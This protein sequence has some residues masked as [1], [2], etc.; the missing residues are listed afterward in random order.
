MQ[1][2]SKANQAR[3]LSL[4]AFLL[5]FRVVSVSAETVSSNNSP[6]SFLPEQ[7]SITDSSGQTTQL[8][9]RM[10]RLSGQL[11][12]VRLEKGLLKKNA[13]LS[14]SC[15]ASYP[16]DLRVN[17]TL[18]PIDNKYRYSL[19]ITVQ[20]AG[21]KKYSP[22]PG[23][24]LLLQ[25]GPGLVRGKKYTPSLYNYLRPIV[26]YNDEVHSFQPEQ[27]KTTNTGWARHQVSW[28]GLHD[29]YFAVLIEPE[30]K[31]GHTFEEIKAVYP[32]VAPYAKTELQ[33][34]LPLQDI[35]AGRMTGYAFK[36][37][38][39]PKSLDTLKP[40]Y[41]DILF[42]KLWWWLRWLSLGLVKLLGWIHMLIPSWGLAIIGLALFVRLLL[43]PIAK[44]ANASQKRFIEIQ[45]VMQ[46]ELTEIK[47]N[48]KG[49]EQSERMMAL[50]KKYNISPFSGMKPIGV[51]LVQLPILVALFQVLGAAYELRGASFLWINSLADP[52]KLFAFGTTLP[53]FGE[54][55]NILPVLMTVI[56][57]VSMKLTPAH[58]ATKQEK[59]R[60]NIFLLLMSAVFFLLFYS[61]PAG[62]VLYWTCANLFQVMQQKLLS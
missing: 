45:K 39:G 61:F 48:Y 34:V 40:E 36:L 3:M 47:K 52:D 26:S 28:V 57:L 23:D 2:L 20:N 4:T 59:T 29:R 10:I 17:C 14:A 35:A 37:Y 15:F 21:N 9:H 46:P 55:F 58:H 13:V 22:K 19:R 11:N 49:A 53:F 56:T 5:F 6:S 42:H 31:T 33:L 24:K 8:S 25:V 32:K 27:H 60:Q 50:Y 51:I 62:M 30:K 18:I 7:W 41:G 38:A 43:Y 1:I 12:G 16:G 44:R 54:Y